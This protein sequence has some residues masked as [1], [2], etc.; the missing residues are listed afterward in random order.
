MGYQNFSALLSTILLTIVSGSGCGT[1]NG[2][3]PN[4]I[5]TTRKMADVN[6]GDQTNT[7]STVDSTSQHNSPSMPPVTPTSNSSASPQTPTQSKTAPPNPTVPAMPPPSPSPNSGTQQTTAK[8]PRPPSYRD[9]DPL[10]AHYYD[11]KKDQEIAESWDYMD[12]CVFPSAVQDPSAP[13]YVSYGTLLDELFAVRDLMRSKYIFREETEDLDPRDFVKPFTNFD[14]HF[15][16]MTDKD[17]Y[18]QQLRSKVKRKDGAPRHGLLKA[19]RDS[20][21]YR[22]VNSLKPFFG[23]AWDQRS[24]NP[25]R[26]YVVKYVVPSSPGWE[27][28]NGSPKIKRG[29]KLLKINNIDFV[30]ADGEESIA[31]IEKALRPDKKSDVTKFELIDRD[32]NQIKTIFL[33]PTAKHETVEFAKILETST[34]FVGYINIAENI[35]KLSTLYESVKDFKEKEVNDVII[36]IRYY[37]V[38]EWWDYKS[39]VES[40]LLYTILGK[41][42]TNGKQF[43]YRIGHRNS[44]WDLTKTPFYSECRALSKE[45]QQNEYCDDPMINYYHRCIYFFNNSRYLSCRTENSFNLKSLNLNKVYLLT[46]KET[47][48][49]GELIINSL[50]GVDVQVVQIGEKT[51][52]TP[53]YSYS[54]KDNCGIVYSF[55]DTKFTNDKKEGDYIFGFKPKNSKDKYGV[56]VP[57]CFVK[58]DFSKD[59][60]N[61]SEAMLATALQYRKDGTCPDVP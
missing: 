54:R 3:S 5:D 44:E 34:G 7:K 49:I 26:N 41:D 33:N 50:L 2:S 12:R 51:C 60:G 57:G 46:S 14:D 1:D 15:K 28:L 21:Q 38:K 6:S 18:Y 61:E 40:M 29:D 43:R 10:P 53:Y 9:R 42:N 30:S 47:C 45:S 39:R 56:E 20:S 36:D 59:L 11:W 37:S 55:Y 22:S 24:V 25:P 16:N 23:I 17:S 8:K 52:G 27:L 35:D 32:S 19:Y 4:Q 58:D 13:N 31:K 48:H